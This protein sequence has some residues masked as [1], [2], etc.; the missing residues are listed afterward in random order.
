MAKARAALAEAKAQLASSQASLH[1]ATQSAALDTRGVGLGLTAPES[2]RTSARDQDLAGHEVELRKAQVD[3][4]KAQLDAARLAVEEARRTL[5]R[6][7]IKAPFGGTVLSVGVER[8]SIVSSPMG[9]VNGGT[10][11][12]TLADLTDLRVIGQLDEAQIGRVH[13]GQAVTFR[14]DAYPE[15]TFTGKVH[16]VSPLGTV[17]TNV[18]VFDVE[19]I[20]TD[21]EVSLLRSGMS[22]DVEIVT[23][24][25][26]G[27]LLIPLTAVR[28]AG[29]QREVQLA[30][31][32]VVPIRTG[33]TDGTNII[34]Q[35]GLQEGDMV[36]T[37][38]RG[39]VSATEETPQR[40][41]L[42]PAPPKGGPR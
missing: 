13:P 4:A 29:A 6:T 32:Q 39:K 18:V 38:G 19:V 20:V 12:I 30:S 25:S 31:G 42:F 40:T 36:V 16:R 22:A 24:H 15:R 41:G 5:D 3:S 28:S 35:D 2:A 1:H 9:N 14:V 26:E 17:D 37:D 7:R 10:A 21:P 8:G 33:A 27:V 34:V 23:A 11:L